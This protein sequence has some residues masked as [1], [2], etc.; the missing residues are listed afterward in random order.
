MRWDH[1]V[2]P[3]VAGLNR[4]Q[5]EFVLHTLSD[6]ARS[7]HVPLGKEACK[8]NFFIIVAQ[9]P[10]A[11]IKLMWR[12]WPALFDT[13]YGIAPVRRFIDLPRPVRIWY[14]QADIGA[15]SGIAFNGALAESAGIGSGSGGLPAHVVPGLR[16][17][18]KMDVVRDIETAM[19]VV[20]PEKVKGF[21]LGRLVD[22]IALIGFAQINLDKDLGPAPSILKVFSASDTSPPIEMT[23]WDRALLRALYSTSQRD[24]LQ[25][26]EMETAMF[27]EISGQH[28]H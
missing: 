6:I 25:L 18:L 23:A 8:A 17:R 10:S 1:P 5:E 9:N 27:N 14:N 12:R 20:D 16:S 28:S 21:N 22:Y 3:L 7:A 4:E 24:T 13:R 2:C 15:D 11:F 19:I 26:S